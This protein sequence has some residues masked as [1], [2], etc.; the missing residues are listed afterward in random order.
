MTEITEGMTEEPISTPDNFLFDLYEE[1]I[2]EPETETDVYIGFGL[3]FAGVAF[4]GVALVTFIAGVTLYGYRGADGY[5]SV[6]QVSYSLALVSAPVTMLSVVVLLPVKK[7]AVYGA[8]AGAVVAG[9]ATAA[10]VVSYPEQWAEGGAG[11][12]LVVMG[13]YAVGVSVVVAATAAALIAHQLERVSA[14]EPSEVEENSEDEGKVSTE[15][16]EQDIEQA[17]EEVDLNLGGVKESENRDLTFK[18]D[19]DET[20]LKGGTSK[21]PAKT[22]GGGVDAQVEG[23]RNMKAGGSKTETSESTVDDQ[24]SA[25][26][27]LRKQKEEKERALEVATKDDTF[28]T[29]LLRKIGVEQ[30]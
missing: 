27:N 23:L 25:L 9:V 24:A 14:P 13:S 10:F 15:Q 26:N 3:F 18:T 21:E 19:F 20:G 30:R 12:M 16:V 2:G 11:R 29:W 7:K 5:F 28:L 17:M 1:Y 6:A 8:L 22:V 4:A